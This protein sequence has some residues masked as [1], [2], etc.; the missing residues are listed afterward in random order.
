[1]PVNSVLLTWVRTGVSTPAET[2]TRRGPN[3]VRFAVVTL[4][5]TG[6]GCVSLRLR[7]RAVLEVLDGTP[8]TEVAERFGVARQTVHRWVARYRENGIDGLA[9]RSHAPKAHP[10]RVSAVWFSSWP[11]AGTRTC[12]GQRFTG[13]WSVIGCLSRCRAAGAGISTAGGRGRRRWS[14]G[15]WT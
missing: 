10:W 11:S 14:C 2:V 8:V 4:T 13:C 5:G 6:V 9:D 12:P 3:W 7:Y 15:R 1:M